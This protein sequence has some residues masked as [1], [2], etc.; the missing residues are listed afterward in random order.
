VRGPSAAACLTH[1]AAATGY[2]RPAVIEQPRL[3]LRRAA[4]RGRRA[5]AS[6]DPVS[7]RR[8]SM[9]FAWRG[10]QGWRVVRPSERCWKARRGKCRTS[11]KGCA[12][13]SSSR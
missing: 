4:C 8:D 10:A 2:I 11:R 13:T 12:R 9:V 3:A 6:R 5:L 7:H 1:E